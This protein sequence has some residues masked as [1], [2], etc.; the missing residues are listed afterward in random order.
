MSAASE[1]TACVATASTN[2]RNVSFLATKSVSE[3]TSTIAA[4]FASSDT[5]T[6]TS[7]SA[8]IRPAFFA[9]F[10]RPFSLKKR[11]PDPYQP[12]EIPE[13]AGAIS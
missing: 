12:S 7:P 4:S 2:S 8:A 10:A 5:A 3:L 6:A 13:C 11:D 1:F 9:A